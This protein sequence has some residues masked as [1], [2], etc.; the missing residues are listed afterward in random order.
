L[1]YFQLIESFLGP[2]RAGL[3]MH[4]PLWLAVHM[5]KQQK[6]RIVPP[7]WMER[8]LLEDKKEEEKREP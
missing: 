4:V 3:P 1:Q 8:D 7:T 6:C 5:K 2:F